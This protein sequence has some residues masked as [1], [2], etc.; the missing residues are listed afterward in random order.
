MRRIASCE[1]CR[2][3]ATAQAGSAGGGA[4]SRRGAERFG[5]RGSVASSDGASR[6]IGT[7]SKALSGAGV[8]TATTGAMVTFFGG[9]SMFLLKLGAWEIGKTGS[10]FCPIRVSAGTHTSTTTLSNTTARASS[11]PNRRVWRGIS[12]AIDALF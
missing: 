6:A 3:G 4:R 10:S 2:R 11:N 5:E 12:K 7:V 8:I 1:C 9:Q